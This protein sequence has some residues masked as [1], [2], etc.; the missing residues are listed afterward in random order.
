LVS[1]RNIRFEGIGRGNNAEQQSE[2]CRDEI[3]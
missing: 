1:E 2:E 3:C